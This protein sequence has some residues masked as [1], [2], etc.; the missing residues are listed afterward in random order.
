MSQPPQSPKPSS[1]P[2]P[3]PSS[4]VTERTQSSSASPS[5]P[6]TTSTDDSAP[7]HGCQWVGCDKVLSDPE[8]LY[9][10]LCNDHI[11]RKSTGN[12]CLTCKWKD[13][14][15][16]CA[17]RDHITS[18]LRVHTP[19]KPHV[20]EICKKPFK[21]P[22]DLKKH[23]KIH[24]EE[25]H[26]QHKH[27]K[28]I[29]V[30]DPAYSQRIRGSEGD[31]ARPMAPS[32]AQHQT[33]VAR[34]KSTSAPLS[35]SSSG[36][37]GVLPTP[38]P[39]LDYAHEAAVAHSRNQLYRIQ[40]PLPTWEVLPED[41]QGRSVP[42]SGAKRSYDYSVDDFFADVK[43][44]RVTPAYD[45]HMAARLSNLAYQQSLSATTHSAQGN[46][47]Q[48]PHSFNPRSVS[49]D[50]RTPEELAA[51]NDF[52]I[53][54]GRD[55]SGHGQHGSRH[56]HSQP[57][58]HAAVDDASFFDPANLAQLG[59]AGM[60]GVPSQGPGSGAS[61]HGDSGFVPLSEFSS[62]QMSTYPSRSSHQSVQAVQ[63][64]MYPDMA[65]G[66]APLPYTSNRSRAHR[67]SSTDDHFGS[68]NNPSPPFPP[69][70]YGMQGYSHY[71]TPPLDLGPSAGNPGASPLSS[72]SGMSTPPT[73]TPP[74]IPLTV[75]PESAAAFDYVRVSRAPPPVV[76]LGP[77]DYSTKSMRTIVPLK[78]AG[79]A[80][81]GSASGSANV[82]SSRPEPV[83]PK[84][85]AGSVHR[86][87]PAKLTASSAASSVASSSIASSKSDPLYPLLTS[88]DERLK[89]PPLGARFRSPSP[90]PSQPAS[91]YA[92]SRAS[93]ASP[94]ASPSLSRR[95]PSPISEDSNTPS[96]PRSSAPTPTPASS[97]TQRV[98][99]PMLP[100]ISSLGS[101]PSASA[102]REHAE[103]LA[104]RV[105][106]IELESRAGSEEE[107]QRHAALLRD[108]LLAIN[109]EYRKRFGTPPPA[110]EAREQLQQRRAE[111]VRGVGKEIRDVE[112]IVA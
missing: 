46:H 8:S 23:E 95:S 96:P 28:A 33:P 103:D 19:L 44:R 18:H 3:A 109:E 14:G 45:P 90:A 59:L 39:E 66:G 88:G 81:S 13:C 41:V 49:F 78:S 108:L 79:P 84:L 87:P 85:G 86:G 9:N 17:K 70:S 83:E 26:A 24:T 51:V 71:L 92:S 29:T 53:T 37:F 11:G 42:V 112:M 104:R 60:P 111:Q 34:A 63:F 98:A 101:Y 67:A 25:H 61:Y 32:S 52:L 93:T 72:H 102:R 21:R 75:S 76:Q 82:L 74:H 68:L 50:I 105:G 10:H 48:L 27:S 58:P 89:L 5:A 36:D 97:E 106:R 2:P 91:S 54:L 99:Y 43:K 55:V 57:V 47:M 100:P 16:T 6:T 40:P 64:G 110:R 4:E 80:P 107:R 35:D 69:Q 20:C 15:T 77:V 94:T 30:T 38:S 1:S 62:Q 22:Q 65:A 73:S 12:L 7:G 56:Q 31:K